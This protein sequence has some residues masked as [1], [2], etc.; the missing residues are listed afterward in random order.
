MGI[1]QS[2]SV[3]KLKLSLPHLKASRR[4]KI[5]FIQVNRNVKAKTPDVKRY[6]NLIHTLYTVNHNSGISFC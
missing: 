4:G 1:I 2:T 5:A 3:Y 6:L